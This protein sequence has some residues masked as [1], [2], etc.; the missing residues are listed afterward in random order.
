MIFILFLISFASSELVNVQHLTHSSGHTGATSLP[1]YGLAFFAYS[2]Q[3]CPSGYCYTGYMMDIY[4]AKT[5]NWSNKTLPNIYGTGGQIIGASFDDLGIAFFFQPGQYVQNYILFNA[6]SNEATLLILPFLFQGGI[7]GILPKEGL[8]FFAGC[9]N[10][11]KICIFDVLLKN[12][13]I[14]ELS[15]PRNSVAIISLPSKNLVFFAGGYHINILYSTNII[16]IW[17]YKNNIWT[18]AKLSTDRCDLGTTILDNYE[19]VFF[20]GGFQNSPVGSVNSNIID[21][22]DLKKNLWSVYKMKNYSPVSSSSLPYN[23]LAF[24]SGGGSNLIYIYYAS[25]NEWKISYLSDV[26]NSLSSISLPNYSLLFFAGVGVIPNNINVYGNCSSGFMSIN[27]Y[28]CNVVPAGYFCGNCVVPLIC[29]TG[30]YC[31]S[32]SYEPIPCIASYNPNIG[33]KTIDSC[34]S[35]PEGNFCPSGSTSPIL[36]NQGTYCPVNVSN[37]ILCPQGTYNQNFGSKTIND[38]LPCPDGTFGQQEGSTSTKNCLPC[39]LGNYCPQRSPAPIACPTNYYCPTTSI[40]IAC[41]IGTYYDGTSAISESSCRKCIPGFYCLGNGAS[42]IP[43]PPGTYTSNTGS[44]QCEICPGGYVCSFGSITKTECPKDTF[45]T[46]GSITCTPCP[47]GQYTDGVASK[48]CLICPSSRFSIEGWWCMSNYERLIFSGIWIGSILSGCIT[49]WK[50]HK[51]V[52]NRLEKLKNAGLS[53]SLKRFI[54]LKKSIRKANEMNSMFSDDSQPILENHKQEIK[55]LEELIISLQNEIKT[56][57]NNNYKQM[58]KIQC[59]Y[60]Y[61]LIIFTLHIQILLKT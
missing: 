42:A 53:F 2:F 12:Y 50:I 4:N 37:Q 24:F 16:D 15:T 57:K 47:S 29:P 52:K 17:D 9:N 44:G 54:F 48:V 32:N 6:S 36:C 43:C 20:A 45:S 26:S 38:C 56:I 34:L 11:G 60:Y 61:D 35:C 25:L 51:Y 23:G 30:N 5:N 58:K 14:V 33:S 41:S 1:S 10:N 8:L 59:I 28:Q 22:Y 7:P 49:I 31:P 19:I 21:I 18:T 27:P 3:N 13:T 40:K 55:R 39:S 46:E